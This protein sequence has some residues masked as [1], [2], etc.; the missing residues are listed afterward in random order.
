M[1]DKKIDFFLSFFINISLNLYSDNGNLILK[2]GF[3]KKQISGHAGYFFYAFTQV[4]YDFL[5]KFV[6]VDSKFSNNE[7]NLIL[8]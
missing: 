6:Q 8:C 7:I 3:N 5:L 4:L 1:R 2:N